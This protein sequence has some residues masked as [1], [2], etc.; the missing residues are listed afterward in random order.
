MYISEDKM[1]KYLHGKGLWGNIIGSGLG[2]LTP[3][4]ACSTIPMT[5]GFLN[6]K[7]PFGA[8]MSFL[9]SSPLLN[10]IIIGMLAAL[11]GIKA[12]ILYFF[13]CFVLSIFFGFILEKMGYDK[14]IKNVRIKKVDSKNDN[15]NI[16]KRLLPIKTKLKLSIKAGINT[17]KPVL[18]YLLIGVAIGA[19]IYGYLPS[20][21]VLKIAGPDNF[22]AVPIAAIVGIPLYI[23]AETAIP[24]AISL[25]DK[26]M[27]IGT[28]MALIIG[29]AG[30]AIPEMSM[31]AG[32]FKIKLVIAIVS[33][34][35]ITAVIS[36]YIF[37]IIL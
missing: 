13:L 27:G 33:V 17:L 25:I 15:I 9:I 6:A 35:F 20:D 36:G 37:N 31:L 32:I 28:A 8:T 30:M 10:P 18:V 1:Q 16:N 29:G 23:R 12:A 11:V 2:A 7:V 24:I 4:C 26:G 19:G 5:V 3:F 34:I 14:Y 22:F 21:F